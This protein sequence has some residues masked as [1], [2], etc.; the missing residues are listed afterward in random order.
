MRGTIIK[1]YGGFFFVRVEDRVF[2]CK[3]RGRIRKRQGEVLVGDQVGLELTPGASGLDDGA[4]EGVITEIYPRDS[5]LSRPPVANVNQAV[6]IFSVDYP[7][8]NTVL[9]DRFLLQ[10]Y[11]A[12]INPVLC[13]NKMD[14]VNFN[15]LTFF[16][17]YEPAGYPM[18]K[19]SAQNGRNIELLKQLLKD[20]ISVFAGPSGVGKSSLLNALEPGLRLKT[21]DISQKLKRGRHTTRHVEL[22]PLTG[23]GMVADTPGFTSMYLPNMRK[24]ELADCYPEF[25]NYSSGCRFTGCL[26]HREPDCAVKEAVTEGHI[27]LLRYQQYTLLLQEVTENERRY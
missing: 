16:K 11:K 23:G 19:V 8:P 1:A 10:A 21:G 13:F 2:R 5:E 14:L 22:I 12:G 25:I 17:E 3:I 7:K 20:K 15:D 4:K 6:I 24:N 26:H 9:L 27:S 18:V